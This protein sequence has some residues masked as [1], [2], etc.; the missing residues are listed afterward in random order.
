MK[1]FS[2]E[3]IK[4]FKNKTEI[5]LKPLTILV[6]R[7]SCGKSS[8][9]RFPVVL[10]QTCDDDSQAP[11]QFYGKLI[12]YGT[13]NDI[14]FNHQGNDISFSLKYDVIVNEALIN[15]NKNSKSKTPDIRSVEIVTHLGMVKDHL[16]ITNQKLYVD[17]NCVFESSAK[18]DNTIFTMHS[19]Y[20]FENGS[21][22][23]AEY[24][25]VDDRSSEFGF[26]CYPPTGE[27]LRECIKQQYF[28]KDDFTY[29]DERARF[30][31]EDMLFGETDDE[32]IKAIR[33]RIKT[34]AAAA[35]AMGVLVTPFA[36]YSMD[37]K[38]KKLLNIS[39]LKH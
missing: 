3:N 20:N 37:K 15:R 17:G 29:D 8:L 39:E 36:M 27:G 32:E 4:S 11:L 35:I 2:V 19:V 38:N 31:A 1:S 26:F 21:F 9:L 24:E 30:N 22:D 7:N 34:N 16:L 25:I 33:K 18:G 28:P 13:F 10:S 23:E 5:E 6:G 12:D 14:V